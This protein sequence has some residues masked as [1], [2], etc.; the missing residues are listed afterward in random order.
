MT[1]TRRPRSTA[2]P[3]AAPA[4]RGCGHR[5]RRAHGAAACGTARPGPPPCRRR[6]CARA[7]P[8]PGPPDDPQP[9]RRPS[10]TRPARRRRGPSRRR[11][12][13]AAPAPRPG[14]WRPEP[15][16]GPGRSAATRSRRPGGPSPRRP[17]PRRTAPRL[18]RSRARRS[19]RGDGRARRARR[20]SPSRTAAMRAWAA[21]RPAVPSWSYTAARNSGCRNANRP[22]P[23]SSAIAAATAS[24]SR[25][26]VGRDVVIGGGRERGDV[27]VAA[28]RGRE[29]EHLPAARGQ[30]RHPFGDR[31]RDRGRHAQVRRARAVGARRA[32][33]RSR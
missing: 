29:A 15:A 2:A 3:A 5:P 27:E 12:R 4:A 28:D 20:P 7:R 18:P 21:A 33:G 6:R 17:P 24:S 8:R 30:A 16:R 25:P 14:R 22:G 23:R 1:P 13:P 9:A 11:R 31:R 19:G 26:S 10:R 32:G